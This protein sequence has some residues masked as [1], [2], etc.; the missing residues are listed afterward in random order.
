M[1]AEP[2]TCALGNILWHSVGGG[3]TVQWEVPVP[4]LSSVTD[5]LGDRRPGA[6]ISGFGFS[7]PS[8][9][10]SFKET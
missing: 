10:N 6:A 7:R 9:E 8:D 2:G 3:G 5:T 4:G 1:Q